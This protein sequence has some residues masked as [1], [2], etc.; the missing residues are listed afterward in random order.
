MNIELE[1]IT[2]D[3]CERAYE[4]DRSDIPYAFVEDVPTLIEILKYGA[5]NELIGNAFLVKSDDRCIGTIML[6]EGLVGEMDPDEVQDIPFYRLMFFVLDKAY[7]GKGIGS[8]V[9]EKAIEITF[10]DF[11]KRPI[12]L[13][14][15]KD[16]EKAA[17][18]YECN[19]FER[20]NYR[21]GDDFYFMR[22][23]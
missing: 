8:E 21:V 11:G 7:R 17:H 23:V 14:V 4:I 5:E 15:Q 6:G 12:V 22:G 18:F 3:N 1:K 19:G 20:T 13:E 10:N 9:M 16:N 2:F